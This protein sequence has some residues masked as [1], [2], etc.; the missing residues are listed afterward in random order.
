MTSELFDQFTII[1]PSYNEA[2]ALPAVLSELQS[3]AP[4]A[5]IIVVDDGSTDASFQL[6][7]QTS[8]VRILRHKNNRGYGAAL[9]TGILAAATPFVVTYDGDGQH[10]PEDALAVAELATKEEFDL[11]IGVRDPKSFQVWSRRPG[12]WLLSKLANYL[13]RTEIPDLNSGLRALK[14]EQILKY[15][16]IMPESFSFST[17]STLAMLNGGFHVGYV[18]IKTKQRLGTSTVSIGDGLDTILLIIRL[19]VLFQP[20]RVF[21]PLSLCLMGLGGIKGALWDWYLLDGPV[22]T[23]SVLVFLTGVIVF[24]LGVLSDQIASLRMQNAAYRTL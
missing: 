21:V 15:L 1:I 5:R 24:C 12:K 4:Q 2:Q 23:S 17:T 11:V 18:P 3:A 19:I 22:R 8:N 16:N 7:S 14:R 10:R 13:C 20:L 6:L 9:K